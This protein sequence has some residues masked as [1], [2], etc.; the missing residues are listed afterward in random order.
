MWI[1]AAIVLVTE[2]IPAAIL[3]PF[4]TLLTLYIFWRSIC[5]TLVRGGINWRGTLYP[6][7]LLKSQ[8]GEEGMD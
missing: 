8:T 7:D 1:F 2:A 5:K 6:L 3:F 4:L